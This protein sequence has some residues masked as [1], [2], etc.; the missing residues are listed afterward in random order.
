VH[1]GNIPGEEAGKSSNEAW[2]ARKSYAWLKENGLSPEVTTITSCDADSVLDPKYFS[3]VADFFA[4]DER[5]QLRFWQ[6]PLFYYNNIWQ[7]PAP[8][9]FTTWLSHAMQVAEL[10]MP[11]FDPLP[12]STYTLSIQ[13]AE[14]CGWWDPGVIPEDWHE[15]LNCMFESGEEIQTT[16]VFLPTMADATDGEGWRQALN[17]RFHQVKRHAW[18]AEDVGFIYGQLTRRP[19]TLR[20]STIFRFTQVLHDHVMRVASWFFLVSVYVLSAYYTKIHWYD[21]NFHY[22][23][24]QNLIVLRVLL[25]M[26]GAIMIGSIVFELWR[27]PPPEGVSK[28]RTAVEIFGLWFTLPLLGFYLGTLPALEAQT[29]LMFNIPLGYRVTPKRFASTPVRK[30]S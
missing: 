26:G 27:C 21:L 6:A 14:R 19:G 1:P 30:P 9:R 7:V 23:I 3:A 10:A 8:I 4:H 13:L 5:R 29:R 20:K 25:T 12:I 16:S 18:G 24:V 17:N 15:Y 11:F 28:L 22:A 2:A